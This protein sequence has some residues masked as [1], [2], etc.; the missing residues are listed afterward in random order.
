MCPHTTLYVLILL[1]VSA[2]YY[3]CVLILLHL[4]SLCPHT[5]GS[6]RDCLYICV[7]IQAAPH[8]ICV[9]I[10]AA[11]RAIVSI[12]VSSYRRLSICVSSYRRLL[13]RLRL[14]D[15]G[16]AEITRVMSHVLD[17]AGVHG[18]SGSSEFFGNWSQVLSSLPASLVQ[19]YK[20]G[21]GRSGTKVHILIRQAAASLSATGRRYSVACLL[22]GYKS[23]NTDQ[24]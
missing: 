4:C 19:K 1:S 15:A 14:P 22:D 9:L 17:E 12:Y 8:Y 23:T 3:I 7:L 5:G 18:V 20:Y 10:Q 11:P 16:D 21:F 6:S 13:A 2:Y 24:V